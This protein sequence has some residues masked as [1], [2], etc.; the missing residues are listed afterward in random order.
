MPTDYSRYFSGQ[1]RRVPSLPQLAVMANG[2]RLP[3]RTP[4]GL[5]FGTSSFQGGGGNTVSPP[6]QGTHTPPYIPGLPV[7]PSGPIPR[8]TGQ[9]LPPSM[10]GQQFLGTGSRDPLSFREW[11]M[12]YGGGGELDSTQMWQQY[13]DYKNNFGGGPGRLMTTPVPPGQPV[14]AN[15]TNMV[16]K[17]QRPNASNYLYI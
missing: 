15:Y 16:P 2:R 7:K 14:Y 12:R 1:R 11:V 8:P 17:A 5:Q 4:G 10:M 9:Q 3:A 6:M 13:E